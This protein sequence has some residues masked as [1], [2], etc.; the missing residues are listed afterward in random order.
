MEMGGHGTEVD[1]LKKGFSRRRLEAH[2]AAIAMS[3]PLEVSKVV[4]QNRRQ[5]HTGLFVSQLFQSWSFYLVC[6]SWDE[7][8][9]DCIGGQDRRGRGNIRAS[10]APLYTLQQQC[11]FCNKI[12]KRLL[13]W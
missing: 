3:W 5:F 13:D 10:E 8:I 7:N 6:C 4:E 11:A 12:Y 9:F 1:G 2:A